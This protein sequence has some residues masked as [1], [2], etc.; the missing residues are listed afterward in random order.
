MLAILANISKH[1]SKIYQVCDELFHVFGLL[2][3]YLFD[4]VYVR[5]FCCG[6]LVTVCFNRSLVSCIRK[7]DP[8]GAEGPSVTLHVYLSRRIRS[9]NLPVSG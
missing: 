4:N 1:V 3:Y 8:R 6:S 7:I 2:Q 5:V 9:R